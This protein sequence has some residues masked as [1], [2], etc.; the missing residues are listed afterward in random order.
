MKF[1]CSLNINTIFLHANWQPDTHWLMA[2]TERIEL[3]SLVLE[4]KVMPL[5]EV[6]I[7]LRGMKMVLEKTTQ[8]GA[9]K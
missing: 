8:T 9:M 3:P 4:T 7:S 6:P 5:Y 2:G 1:L